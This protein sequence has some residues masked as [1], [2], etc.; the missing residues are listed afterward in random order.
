MRVYI[1]GKHCDATL[2]SVIGERCHRTKMTSVCHTP[3]FIIVCGALVLLVKLIIATQKLHPR[4]HT[5]NSSLSATGV[6]CQHRAQD[7][8]QDTRLHDR[9][10][11]LR[12]QRM[13]PRN[14]ACLYWYYYATLMFGSVKIQ[15]KLQAQIFVELTCIKLKRNYLYVRFLVRYSVRTF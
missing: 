1:V 5:R 13:V 11:S 15:K 2:C 8:I 14:R 6:I 9:L 12:Y 10:I 4:A 3:T 7:E